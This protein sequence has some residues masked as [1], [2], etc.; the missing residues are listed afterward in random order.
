MS[1]GPSSPQSS[2]TMHVRLVSDS[3]ELPVSFSEARDYLYLTEDDRDKFGRLRLQLQAAVGLCERQISGHRSFVRKTY[4][5]IL[6]EFP[7]GRIEIPL[8]PL[9]SSTSIA[10]SYYDGDNALQTLSS[11]TWDVVAPSDLPAFVQPKT[12]ESWPATY[13]RPDAVTVRFVAGWRDQDKVPAQLK[14]A[15][16]MR[17]EQLWDPARLDP[18]EMDRTIKS[19]LDSLDYGHYA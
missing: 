9:Y 16:L 7:A 3:T 13:T 17:L 10:I 19:I 15:C 6:A 8:P 2:T 4:D 1:N 5:G 14:V 12:N 11:T 18:E